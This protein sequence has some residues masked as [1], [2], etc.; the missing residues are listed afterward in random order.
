ML[1]T[2]SQN[3]LRARRLHHILSQTVFDK[4]TLW[5]GLTPC[6]EPSNGLVINDILFVASWRWRMFR[7]L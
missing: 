1:S 4:T 6:W 5:V 2:I 7:P 3:F